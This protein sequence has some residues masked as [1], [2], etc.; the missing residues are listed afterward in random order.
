MLVCVWYAC[1]CAASV[2]VSKCISC[3]H[4]SCSTCVRIEMYAYMCMIDACGYLCVLFLCI[5]YAARTCICHAY[6][7]RHVRM[8]HAYAYLCMFVSST[9]AIRASQRPSNR[10]AHTHN[11][12]HD[13]ES[14][15]QRQSVSTQKRKYSVTLACTV[16]T[17]MQVDIH[18]RQGC[19]LVTRW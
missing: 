2:C 3:K 7:S 6:V 16:R 4:H 1:M 5:T 14:A 12:Y 11:S 10:A 13:G 18:P 17:C 19:G 9:Y 8:Q 15:H